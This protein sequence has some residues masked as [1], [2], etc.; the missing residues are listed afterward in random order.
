MLSPK[1]FRGS[2]SRA[3]EPVNLLCITLYN[4]TRQEFEATILSTVSALKRFHDRSSGPNDLSA[5]CVIADGTATLDAGIRAALASWNRLGEASVDA[6]GTRTYS[7]LHRTEDLLALLRPGIVTLSS[8]SPSRTALFVAIKPTN[9]GKLDSHQLFFAHFCPRLNPSYCYQ[10]D[11]GTVVDVDLIWLLAEQMRLRPDIGGVAPRVTPE[12]PRIGDSFLAKWQFFDFAFR[13]CIEWPF[14]VLTGYLSVLPGQVC[15]FR[16]DALHGAVAERDEAPIRA[17]LEGM[18]LAS[19]IDR[20]RY[21]AEDRVIGASLIFAPQNRWQIA[22]VPQAIG[23]TDRCDS[24][25]ELL[26]QRRRWINSAMLARYW[27]MLQIPGYARRS[28]RTWAQKA[29]LL[30]SAASQLLI[31]CREFFTPAILAALIMVLVQ[32]SFAVSTR[33]LRATCIAFFAAATLDVVFSMYSAATSGK[34]VRAAQARGVGVLDYLC[35]L[36]YLAVVLSFSWPVALLLLLPAAALA[37]SILRLPR[38]S[39]GTMLRQQLSPIT[40]LTMSL[41]ISLYALLR[42]DDISWGTKGLTHVDVRESLERGLVRLRNVTVGWWAM[43]NLTLFALAMATRRSELNFVTATI[44][45]VDGFLA[46]VGLAFVL[47]GRRR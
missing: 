31:G 21:L 4:E 35:P 29:S 14:E 25:Q 32:H 16:W 8:G 47:W 17:Y 12:L 6:D 38:K 9:R 22:Y 3:F 20:V 23:I 1:T 18:E 45:A 44:C 34:P 7:S 30:G 10:I 5:I 28:D 13:A 26:R 41:A 46:L 24:F 40:M 2:D 37:P 42:M 27:L 43:V 19:P 33:A 39:F 36:L 11:V 15:A